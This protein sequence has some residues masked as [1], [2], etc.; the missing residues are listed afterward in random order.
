MSHL[1]NICWSTQ[2]FMGRVGLEPSHFHNSQCIVLFGCPWGQEWERWVGN[3]IQSR[4]LVVIFNMQVLMHCDLFFGCPGKWGRAS[5]W[6]Q[7]TLAQHHAGPRA[8]NQSH[9]G[10]NESHWHSRRLGQI[11]LLHSSGNVRRLSFLF[12]ASL[13]HI[14]S[15]NGT[16]LSI[17]VLRSPFHTL[18]YNFK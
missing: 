16:W 7:E 4:E 2:K 5:W 14:Q 3:R 10:N 9:Q 18:L 8:A 6:L 17:L 11:S 1:S 12:F 15:S 13:D